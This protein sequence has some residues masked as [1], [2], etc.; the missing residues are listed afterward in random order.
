M[1]NFDPASFMQ[2]IMGTL[3]MTVGEQGSLA[4]AGW[5]PPCRTPGQRQPDRHL[6]TNIGDSISTFTGNLEG[7]FS[8][9]YT[10][11]DVVANLPDW[12]R[13]LFT[14]VHRWSSFWSAAIP[15]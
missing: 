5:A 13:L 3:N 12:L 1:D 11:L 6:L 4:W 2:S 15:H 10:H 14:M 7:A 9:T 8:K